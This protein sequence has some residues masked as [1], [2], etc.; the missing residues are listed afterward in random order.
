VHQLGKVTKEVQNMSMRLRMLPLKQT[1]QK[2]ER[3]ARDAAGAVGKRMRLIVEGENTELDR[4]LLDNVS[5]PLVHLIRNAIDHGLESE[6]V[7]VSRGKDP[8]G[9]IHLLAFHQSGRLVIE[10]RDDGGGIDCE[11]VRAKA[12]E[13]GIIQPAIALTRDEA[14]QLIFY[15]GFST[16]SE[17]TEISGRGVGMD[18]VKTQISALQGEIEIET[19]VG[20]GSCF[21]LFLPLSL[22]IMDGLVVRCGSERYVIPLSHVYESIRPSSDDVQFKSGVGEILILGEESIPLFRLSRLLARKEV[23]ESA[24]D[25]I[26]IVVRTHSQPCAILVDEIQ[27][28][29]QVVIKKLGS[30]IR[31]LTGFSGSTILGDGRPALILEVADLIQRQKKPSERFMEIERAGI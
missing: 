16:K 3:V 24:V 15:T 17:V 18:V 2:M 28:Q 30:Q 20:K 8:V 11:R 29:N 1:F 19:E 21:R 14:L 7:R 12:I 26:A 25:S 4:T 23:Q 27:G 31:H 22:W 5:D 6:D 13:K 10:V 9:T